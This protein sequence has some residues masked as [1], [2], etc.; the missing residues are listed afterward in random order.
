[1]KRLLNRIP[2]PMNTST[3]H[4]A[5][6]LLLAAGAAAPAL[7][8]APE[9]HTRTVAD[10]TAC[11][12]ALSD[13]ALTRN[14]ALMSLDMTLD[15]ADFDLD[16]NR[17]AVFTPALIKG[18]DTLAL[19]PLGLYS[20]TRWYQYLRAGERPLGGP[21]E[22]SM[23]YGDRP[24]TLVYAQTF[25]YADWM[26]GAD[27]WLLRADYGCCR[28]LKDADR[29]RLTG[30]MQYLPAFRYVRPV[31]DSLKQRELSGRAYVDFPVNRTE[32]YPDYRNN[33]TELTRIIATI[34][35]VRADADVTVRALSIKGFASPEGSYA[36]NERLARGRTAALKQYVRQLYRFDDAFIQTSYE[37]EDWDGLRERV[38]ADAA[39]L[40]HRDA[41]LAIIDDTT[42]DPDAKD[43]RLKRTYP[44][45]YAV[46][47]RDIYPALRHSD[48]RIEYTIRTYTDVAEIRRVMQTA[49]QKLS[50]NEFF[51]LAQTLEVGSAEYNEVF[52]TA[53]RMY[54]TDEVANLNAANAAMSRK[55]YD[56]AARYLDKAGAGP[57]A[58][59]ARGVYAAMRG[60][61]E[62]A[63]AAFTQVEST[64]PEAAEALR[65]IRG[66]HHAL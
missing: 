36:N 47:L 65:L 25:A 60:D 8:A 56:A 48:Y 31:A 23:R 54:P 38:L 9:A 14:D 66:V 62:A 20:R 46:I 10:T 43:A 59:Y 28:T 64:F 61:Y 57:E 49:P 11:G 4:T 30:W 55:D 21:D 45:D 2:R 58:V 42:L 32:I 53:V 39:T 35:S 1:M 40:Q 33:V 6:L 19:Q 37:P 7:Q 18:S 17:V 29:A 24:D 3:L 41:I 50:L 52:E 15:L 12:I 44:D 51:L 26:N 27:L 13:V 16:G 63:T 22:Q 5:A 34:D